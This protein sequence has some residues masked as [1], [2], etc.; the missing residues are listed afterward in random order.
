MIIIG[1]KINATLDAVKSIILN[2]D[3]KSL[4]DLTQKQASAG[5]DYIDREYSR[6]S[7]NT[8]LH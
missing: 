8:A 2:R 5:A 7:H 1:E 4:L 6:P 3:T